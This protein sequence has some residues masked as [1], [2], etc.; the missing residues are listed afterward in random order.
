MYVCMMQ[1]IVLHNERKR[2]VEKNGLYEQRKHGFYCAF[3]EF[4]NEICDKDFMYFFFWLIY[5]P[6]DVFFII[7]IIITN[8]KSYF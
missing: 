7:S 8:I 6:I 3:I 1:L 2:D 4:H 5:D